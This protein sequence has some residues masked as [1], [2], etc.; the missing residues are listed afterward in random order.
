MNRLKDYFGDP[1]EPEPQDD[2]FEIES[3][4]ASFAVSKETAMEIERRLDQLP[5]PRWVA[6]RDL[7]GARHRIQA[8]HIYRVSEST[9][10]Q[11]AASR[12]FHR[13]RRLE[14]KKDRRP[15]EEDD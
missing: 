13:A 15:W 1:Q 2:F 4:W 10:A 6:F 8:V 9:A 11:R 5:P 7:A 3:H 12:E 14:E